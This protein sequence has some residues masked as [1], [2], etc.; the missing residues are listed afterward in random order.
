MLP[1]LTYAYF[2]YDDINALLQEYPQS[3]E[4]HEAE[5][6]WD[7]NP[8][9]GGIPEPIIAPPK[10]LLKHLLVDHDPVIEEAA[11][12][13]NHPLC[14]S[15]LIIPMQLWITEAGSHPLIR[16]RSRTSIRCGDVKSPVL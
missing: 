13:L 1:V 14:S 12:H 3:E 10:V 2:Q 4:G 9:G 16:M 7:T 11:R 15:T 5:V 8:I 6:A